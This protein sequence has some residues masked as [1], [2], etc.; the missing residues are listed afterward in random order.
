MFCCYQKSLPSRQILIFSGQLDAQSQ[1]L[2]ALESNWKLRS[3]LEIRFQIDFASTSLIHFLRQFLTTSSAACA[4][5]FRSW[6]ASRS[7]SFVRFSCTK[8]TVAW[9]LHLYPGCYHGHF[10][11]DAERSESCTW[12]TNPR[13]PNTPCD[14][15]RPARFQR[16]TCTYARVRDSDSFRFCCLLRNVAICCI[17]RMNHTWSFHVSQQSPVWIHTGQEL[18]LPLWHGPEAR[19]DHDHQG[20]AVWVCDVWTKT[21]ADETTS[22]WFVFFIDPLMF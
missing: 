20:P 1:G 14:G 15:I 10:R 5:S 16:G 12:C 6:V 3:N 18:R 21:N 13:H 19:D 2:P 22:L 11:N 7:S 17:C 8:C 4:A 9:E